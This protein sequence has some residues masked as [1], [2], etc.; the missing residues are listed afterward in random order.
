MQRISTTRCS[1]R[2][3]YTLSRIELGVPH[4]RGQS[5]GG[6]QPLRS[7]LDSDQEGTAVNNASEASCRRANQPPSMPL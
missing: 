7:P 6:P 4:R 5:L 1:T 3:L 2:P